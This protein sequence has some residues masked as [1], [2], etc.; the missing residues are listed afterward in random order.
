MSRK[1]LAVPFTI[2]ALGLAASFNGCSCSGEAKMG[3]ME[4]KAPEP[5]PPP[6][7]PA[8]PPPPPPAPEPVKPVVAFGK[9]RIEGTQIKVPGA[10]KFDVDKASIR[11]DAESKEVLNTL[12]E[13]MKANPGINK[14]RI[15]GHTDNTGS[16]DHN[17]K[18]SQERAESVVKWLADHGLDKNRLV[19]MG[20]GESRSVAA[21]DTEENKQK[22]R[23]TEFHIQEKDGK[24]VDEAPK[25]AAIAPGAPGAEKAMNAKDT[26]KDAKKDVKAPAPPAAPKK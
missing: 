26:A 23:R 18:L 14:L 16:P 10:I 12:L 13:T 3:N 9:A 2:L 24:V 21:N 15:E 25:M 19:P 17:Q 20:F 4:A 1:T 6:P 22:N 11:E 8:P 7:P 5:P